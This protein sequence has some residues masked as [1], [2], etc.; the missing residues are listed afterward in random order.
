MLLNHSTAIPLARTL[1]GSR[2]M[3][4]DSTK[5]APSSLSKIDRETASMLNPFIGRLTSD[6]LDKVAD[7]IEAL[8]LIGIGCADSPCPL[9]YDK[10]HDVLET[11]EV[12][13]R[14]EIE[15]GQSEQHQ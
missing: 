7:F 10:L 2:T 1:V 14:Y 11:V 4:D 12:A 5:T 15:N 8:R 13:L 6:S 9:N 3:N